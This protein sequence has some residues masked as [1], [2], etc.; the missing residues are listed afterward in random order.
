MENYFTQYNLPVKFELDAAKLRARF[1]ELSRAYHPDRFATA[2]ADEQ[3]KALQQSA[4]TNEGYKML[5]NADSRIGYLLRLK[6]VLEE[7]EKYTLPAAFL[8]EMMDLNEVVTEYEIAPDGSNKKE[9]YNALDNELTSWNEAVTPLL[10][11]F[12]NG[13]ES[14]ALLKQ[15]KDYYFRKK[16]LLRIQERLNTFAS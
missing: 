8:M 12:D 3:A 13:E 6:G 2:G 15:I 14:E 5:G 10:A 16:Y 7:E 11:R 1:L 4:L 9:A